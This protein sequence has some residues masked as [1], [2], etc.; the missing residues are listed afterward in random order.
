[1]R[2]GCR[3]AVPCSVTCAVI[4]ICS[5]TISVTGISSRISSAPQSTSCAPSERVPQ[6]RVC[7]LQ[8]ATLPGDLRHISSPLEPLTSGPVQPIRPLLPLAHPFP[9]AWQS[10][11]SAPSN[12]PARMQAFA[13][14][15]S[16]SS[17]DSLRQ[18]SL[19][20]TPTLTSPELHHYLP[21]PLHVFPPGKRI[22]R[23][24]PAVKHIPSSQQ[25]APLVDLPR[26]IPPFTL[27]TLVMRQLFQSLLPSINVPLAALQLPF[28]SPSDTA[29]VTSARTSRQHAP[30]ID[31]PRYDP[32]TALSPL[33]LRRL[34]QPLPSPTYTF[35]HAPQFS[36]FALHRPIWHG[37]RMRPLYNNLRRRHTLS[38]PVTPPASSTLASRQTFQPSSKFVHAFPHKLQPVPFAL[39]KLDTSTPASAR[40]QLA[41]RVSAACIIE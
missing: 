41:A 21:H 3:F 24:V 1:M 38:R 31:A 2:A 5:P 30:A 22:T 40:Q 33:E 14:P 27:P 15:L 12:L 32:R 23:L 36:P 16:A 26:E 29:H 10:H 20:R 28:S 25:P 9:H 11:F 4:R 34:I 39:S 37:R 19:T 17:I 18:L 35:T 13:R 8:G 7:T 6:I